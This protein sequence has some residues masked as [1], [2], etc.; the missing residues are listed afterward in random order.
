MDTAHSTDLTT[1]RVPRHQ[2]VRQGYSGKK[3]TLLGVRKTGDNPP[4]PSTNPTGHTFA[5]DITANTVAADTLFYDAWTVYNSPG[6]GFDPEP[7]PYTVAVMVK[8]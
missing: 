4:P 1:D 7:G 6:D 3:W 5:A 2:P 8:K